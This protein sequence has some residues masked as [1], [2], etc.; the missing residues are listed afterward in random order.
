MVHNKHSATRT[1]SLMPLIYH[2]MR[3][4]EWDVLLW[5][6][7]CVWTG[8]TSLEPT[9]FRQQNFVLEQQTTAEVCDFQLIPGQQP[10]LP[11]ASSFIQSQGPKRLVTL[12]YS[13]SLIKCSIILQTLKIGITVFSKKA[14]LY[15]LEWH[16]HAHCL[17]P[18]N[19]MFVAAIFVKLG[20]HCKPKINVYI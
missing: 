17:F 15:F 13:V 7:R 3:K 16:C 4:P 5:W 8:K 18:V 14:F 20:C 2:N 12:P 6:A 10:L 11:A 19:S 9:V 1:T